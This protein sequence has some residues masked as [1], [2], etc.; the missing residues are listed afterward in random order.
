MT[1]PASVEDIKKYRTSDAY[2]AAFSEI[3]Y[4]GL[5]AYAG[6][7]REEFLPELRGKQGIKVYKEMSENDPVVGA[8]LFAVGMLIRQTSWSLTPK[9]ESAQAVEAAEFVDSCRDDMSQTWEDV[10]SEILTMLP[11]GW[12]WI[13]EVYKK[14]GA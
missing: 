3:G 12:A 8:V 4:T 5:N 14:R 6:T 1:P 13:E 9:D 7:L 10:M 2:Q 11:F